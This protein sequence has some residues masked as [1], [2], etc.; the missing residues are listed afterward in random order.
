MV[1]AKMERMVAFIAEVTVRWAGN[2]ALGTATRVL[3][4]A[5]KGLRNAETSYSM[6]LIRISP[7]SNLTLIRLFPFS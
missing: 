3:T 6:A 4:Y 2:V 1:F 5:T 7:E